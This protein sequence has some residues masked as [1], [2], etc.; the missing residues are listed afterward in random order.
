MN[1]QILKWEEKAM[2]HRIET[3]TYFI[4]LLILLAGCSGCGVKHTDPSGID[5][6]REVSKSSPTQSILDET[7]DT[8]DPILDAVLEPIELPPDFNPYY[9]RSW[10][11]LTENNQ[12]PPPPDEFMNDPLFWVPGWEIRTERYRNGEGESHLVLPP[13]AKRETHR[14]RL[15]DEITEKQGHPLSKAQEI[16]VIKK[17]FDALEGVSNLHKAKYFG[18]GS[19]SRNPIAIYYAEKAHAENPDDFHTLWVLANIQ[20][21]E[22]Y[23]NDEK[24]F[25]PVYVARTVSSYHRLLEMNPNIAR[26]WYEYAKVAVITTP[27]GKGDRA[28]SIAA[29]K[30]SFELDPT[31]YYGDVLRSLAIMHLGGVEN[32]KA[33]KYIQQWQVIFPHDAKLV[34]IED[35]K[36]GELVIRHSHD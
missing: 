26:L 25:D 2:K 15:I 21:Q 13:S 11:G 7:G 16:D 4:T 30:K 36:R 31:L 17:V 34:M 32:D 14:Q 19:L 22:L 35:F 12:K 28:A 29:H 33:V 10:V 8:P 6:S 24:S 1:T 23:M 18:A 27:V 20:K 9:G 3:L 5:T